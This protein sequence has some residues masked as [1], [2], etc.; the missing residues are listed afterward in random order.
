MALSMP[1]LTIG[2]GS[3]IA[4]F[5]VITLYELVRMVGVARHRRMIQPRWT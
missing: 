3:M 5:A 4:A 1:A 2:A